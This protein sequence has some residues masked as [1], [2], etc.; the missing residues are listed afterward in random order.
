[1]S[2]PQ[3]Q[4]RDFVAQ[5][6]QAVANAMDTWTKTVEQSVGALPTNPAQVDPQQVVNQVF[7]FAERMLHLQR[8]LTTNLLTSTR[9]LASQATGQPGPDGAAA[10]QA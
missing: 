5:N 8:D 6:Q 3:D 9:T 7:D 4:Y 10:D 2:N 1:M